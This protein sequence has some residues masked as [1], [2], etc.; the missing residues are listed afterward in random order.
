MKNTE[1]LNFEELTQAELLN[2]DGGVRYPEAYELGNS[3]GNG[4]RRGIAVIGMAL[5]FMS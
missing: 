3:I 1:S 5:L 2:F 4:I